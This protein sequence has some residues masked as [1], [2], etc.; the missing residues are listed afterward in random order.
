LQGVKSR[1]IT[2][3]AAVL[4]AATGAASV[5][6][7]IVVGTGFVWGWHTYWPNL[8]YRYGPQW[9]GWIGQCGAGLCVD[10][11]YLR[12]AI[13]REIVQFEHLRD[14]EQR[15][16]PS[17][18]TFARP[19]YL[20]AAGWPPPTPEAHV[21]PAYRRSGEIRPEFSATGQLRE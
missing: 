17:L 21:Q 4:L 14:L 7:Q 8:P 12:R 13:Q 2:A 16:Q 20:A 5:R 19:L 3:I 6:A 15:T 10:S 11:P 18:H 1:I 9:F